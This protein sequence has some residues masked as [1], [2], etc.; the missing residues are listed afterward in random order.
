[1]KFG[2]NLG[3]QPNLAALTT[4][5]YTVG[6]TANAKTASTSITIADGD[7]ISDAEVANA[8]VSLAAEIGKL[9]ADLAAFR[10]ALNE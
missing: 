2:G 9:K 8:V 6:F 5:G 3:M 10:T 4:D 1:M 7:A